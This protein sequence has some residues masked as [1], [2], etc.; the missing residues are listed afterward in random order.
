MYQKAIQIK[1][2]YAKAYNNLGV[3]YYELGNKKKAIELYE[4]SITFNQTD[5]SPYANI[6][7]IFDRE[8]GDTEASIPYYKKAIELN[9][10]NTAVIN[11]AKELGL[12]SKERSYFINDFVA[13][14]RINNDSTVDVEEQIA[15]DFTGGYNKGWRSISHKD[16]GAITDIS[17]SDSNGKRLEYSSARLEK[18]DPNSWGKY[19][20]RKENDY[21]NVEWYYN[22]K[23]SRQSWTIGYKVHGQ[24]GFYKDY[25]EIYWNLFTEYEVRVKNII[26]KVF[27]PD[28]ANFIQKA[29]YRSYPSYQ[30]QNKDYSF[31]EQT[32]G[33]FVF[34][35]NDAVPMEKVTLALGFSKGVVTRLAYFKDLSKLYW[36]VVDGILILVLTIILLLIAYYLREIRPRKSKTIIAEYE[37]PLGLRPAE[38]DLIYHEKLSKKAWPATIIDLAVR[39]YLKIEEEKISKWGYAGRIFVL[40]LIV[41]F[42]LLFGWSYVATSNYTGIIIILVFFVFL[43]SVIM[44]KNTDYSIE[45]LRNPLED[46]EVR[47]YEKSFLGALFFARQVFST[48]T[49]KAS[50]DGSRALYLEMKKN[51]ESFLESFSQKYSINYKKL[52]SLKKKR[53]G[54]KFIFWTIFI[55]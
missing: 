36:G 25:D 22:E 14:L 13:T 38:M 45:M 20:Y 19:T 8:M 10:P 15:Y 30:G 27:L 31:F 32:S 43:G 35:A 44:K 5:P 7:L 46:I 37:P 47:P 55:I 39:G 3:W 34:K 16:I 4:K 1:P 18:T 9:S 41:I 50:P 53:Q 28:G 24:V 29:F 2:D 21:T 33:G 12:L 51:E 26:A 11:R 54:V 40:V 6:A 23:D 48:K 17:I 42:S 52:P 49:M